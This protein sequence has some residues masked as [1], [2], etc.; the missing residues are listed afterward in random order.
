[1][2]SSIRSRAVPYGGR[3]FRSVTHGSGLGEGKTRQRSWARQIS[4]MY[5]RGNFATCNGTHARV[6]RVLLVIRCTRAPRRT[7]V[8]RQQGRL[9]IGEPCT[10][11]PPVASRLPVPRTRPVRDRVAALALRVPGVISRHSAR[12]QSLLAFPHVYGRQSSTGSSRDRLA[13]HRGIAGC[14][15]LACPSY[16]ARRRPSGSID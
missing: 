11:I 12:P 15:A 5:Q 13:V 9:G 4:R 6:L 3:M 8:N 14:I 1:M 16:E 2:Q 10:A 7:V